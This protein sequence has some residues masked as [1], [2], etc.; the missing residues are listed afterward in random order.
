MA[1]E[2]V[3]NGAPLKLRFFICQV[4]DRRFKSDDEQLVC[5]KCGNC[6]AESLVGVYVDDD[7]E[8]QHW[9]NEVDWQ[10]GE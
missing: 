1:T 10:S 6:D 7:P 4:C 5:P 8:V 3:T 2:V 9:Y